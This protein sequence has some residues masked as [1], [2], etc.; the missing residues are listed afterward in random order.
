MHVEHSGEHLALE[1]LK[2]CTI[3]TITFSIYHLY[4][5][6]ATGVGVEKADTVVFFRLETGLDGHWWVDTGGKRIWV[7]EYPWGLFRDLEESEARV[8]Y[9]LWM[10]VWVRGLA[11]TMKTKSRFSERMVRKEIVELSP[12]ELLRDYRELVIAELVNNF[13]GGER[14]VFKELTKR[15]PEIRTWEE[16]TKWLV[17]YGKT[18]DWN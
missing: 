14:K 7:G 5:F 4:Q 3:N 15:N 6:L 12:Q 13:S 1:P 2:N 11:V 10:W 8:A 18:T 16:L 17:G 9:W